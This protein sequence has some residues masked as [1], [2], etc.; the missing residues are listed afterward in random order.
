MT[1]WREKT[2]SELEREWDDQ[3]H[4]YK[5]LVSELEVSLQKEREARRVERVQLEHERKW[6]TEW[7]QLVD[8]LRQE[9]YDLENGSELVAA[10]LERNEHAAK[11]E[12]LLRT[13]KDMRE[14]HNRALSALGKIEDIIDG[15]DV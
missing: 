6:N 11:N 13:I 5:R 1:I 9:K 7:A 4:V 14:K 8:K 12:L 10:R 2:C 15:T 3:R